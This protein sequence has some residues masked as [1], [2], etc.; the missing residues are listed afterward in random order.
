MNE[1]PSEASAPAGESGSDGAATTVNKI[2]A[3]VPPRPAILK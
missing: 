3:T 1:T 2:V